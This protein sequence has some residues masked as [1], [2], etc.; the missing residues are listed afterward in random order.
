MKIEIGPK[1][2]SKW[3]QNWAQS[4]LVNAPKVSWW[5]P[6]KCL[7]EY[8]QSALANTI[9]T[10]LVNTQSIVFY[11]M[12]DIHLPGEY[13]IHLPGEYHIHL[14]GEYHIHLPSEYH[15]AV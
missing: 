1:N 11:D 15:R 14:P 4:V 5:I 12:S 13:H 8:P 10:Y 9:F 3:P 2:E 6:P 7:G